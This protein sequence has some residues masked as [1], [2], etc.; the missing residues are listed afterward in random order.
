MPRRATGTVAPHRWADGRT[1]TFRLKVRANGKRYTISLGT[2]HEGW[3]MERAQ[4]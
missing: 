3:S 2:N 1:I 4:V